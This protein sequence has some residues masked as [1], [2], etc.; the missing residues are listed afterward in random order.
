MPAARQ[1]ALPAGWMFVLAPEAMPQLPKRV[2]AE[3][4]PL[5]QGLPKAGQAAQDQ[6]GKGAA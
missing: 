5:Q 1:A 4:M 2:Q 3:R 6:R